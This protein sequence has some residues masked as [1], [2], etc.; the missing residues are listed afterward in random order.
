[1]Y[2]IVKFQDLFWVKYDRKVKH[3]VNFY[4]EIV[5]YAH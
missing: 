5:Q 2:Y 1:M 3:M 4:N